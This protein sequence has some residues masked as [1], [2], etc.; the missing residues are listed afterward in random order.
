MN[1][2][3][4]QTIILL[5]IKCLCIFLTKYQQYIRDIISYRKV[6]VFKNFQLSNKK[7]DKILT[8][9]FRNDI[10]GLRAIAVVVV[11]IFH[12]GYLPNGYLGVDIFFVISGFLI[13]GILNREFL[14]G[15]YSLI[16]FY[17][18]RTR[19]IIPLVLLVNFIA[20]VLGFIFML[21]DDYENLGQSVVATNL[22]SNNILQY[23]TLGDYWDVMNDYKPLMHTWSLG[24]EEQYYLIFPLLFLFLPKKGNFL[25][26]LLI[27]LT[28]VSLYFFVSSENEAF[29]FYLLP[30]RFFEIS[31]GGVAA[32]IVSKTKKNQIISI[33]SLF[34]L[35]GVVFCDIGLSN[36]IELF[37]AVVVTG[38]ILLFNEQQSFVDKIL[39]LPPMVFIG[40]ISFS[41]Y[42]WHQLILAFYRYLNGTHIGLL[43]SLFILGLTVVLSVMSFHWVEDTFRRK[44][45]I[46]N[47]VLFSTVIISFLITTGYGLMV[48]N[49]GGIM[50][51]FPV[52][53]LKK[54]DAKKNIHSQYNKK[55][56]AFNKNFEAS[57]EKKLNVLIIGD[58]FGRDWGNVLL[59]S[60]YKE[61]ISISYVYKWNASA[62]RDRL[63]DAD[64]VFVAFRKGVSLAEYKEYI[65]PY[66]QD[67][68]LYFVGTKNFGD[69]SGIYY[70]KPKDD[71]YCDQM[72]GVQ[73]EILDI[74]NAMRKLW[75][76]RYIDIIEIIG[77]GTN[78]MPV[79]TDNCQLISQDTRHLTQA[80]AVYFAHKINLEDFL[81]GSL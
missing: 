80:G 61:D 5:K 40:K 1:C 35:L 68:T 52:M 48:H 49:K 25:F 59:E 72:A 71:K 64:I 20:L 46:S 14:E 19:R 2:L 60:D 73:T 37:I 6:V 4:F 11:F 75:G 77:G 41:I 78:S 29:S 66:Q 58:S 57:D 21:P 53:G 43:P 55:I 70:N 24:V 16:K 18:R 17:I 50:K 63:I 8:K 74:N 79:F 38:L 62:I 9:Q 56:L 69:N 76:D 23:I 3:N 39:S 65:Q 47:K 27:F 10:Q 44:D 15:K 7:M 26:Y 51:D 31:I 45:K 42:M 13:T 30:T 36:N 54:S 32:L 81:Y 28:F 67:K 12:L 33:L 34:F 22:F